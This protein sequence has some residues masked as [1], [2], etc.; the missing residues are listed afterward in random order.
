[1]A[2]WRGA[3]LIETEEGKQ[4]SALG[5]GYFCN[6]AIPECAQAIQRIVQNYI[7]FNVV[8]ASNKQFLDPGKDGLFRIRNPL[9][10]FVWVS[11]KQ[12]GLIQDLPRKTRS[13]V[14][15]T[16]THV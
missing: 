11:F 16:R 3:P 10:H 5:S 1:M 14:G 9:R 15:H 2:A 7:F 8:C 13:S 4:K 6:D 12:R